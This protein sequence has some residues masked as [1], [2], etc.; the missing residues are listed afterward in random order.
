[1][2]TDNFK[3]HIGQVQIRISIFADRHGYW[4]KDWCEVVSVEITFEDG[5]TASLTPDEFK[6]LPK[7][8][9]ELVEHAPSSPKVPP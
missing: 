6:A 4:A 3:S 9:R 8:Q 2:I 1:M 5:V 7:E